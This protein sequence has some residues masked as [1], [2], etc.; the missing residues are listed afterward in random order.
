MVFLRKMKIKYD[1]FNPDKKLYSYTI[2]GYNV[3]S[4]GYAE[5]NSFIS[6]P[7]MLCISLLG[8]GND[9][10]MVGYIDILSDHKLYIQKLRSP[11]GK[12]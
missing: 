1:N 11:Y 5:N 9:D 8:N 10:A 2:Y 3:I 12:L 7:H 4:Y 6:C